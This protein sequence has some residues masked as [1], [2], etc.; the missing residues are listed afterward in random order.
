LPRPSANTI[1]V[2]DVASAA[3]VSMATVSRVLNDKP[4]VDQDLRKRV[5]SAVTRL[6]YTPHAAARALASQRSRTIGAVIP[7]L[8]NINFA[9]GVAALQRRITE[10]GY[11]LLL[12]SSNYDRAEELRQVRAL[13][14][15][16]VAGMMLVG[17][18]H[19]PALYELLRTKRIP[20]VNTW[21]LDARH[22]CVGFDNREIGRTLAR[23]LLDLGHVRFGV[24]SQVA[25][26]SD[27]AAER[28]IG[29][30]EVLA[31]RGVAMPEERL[32]ERPYKIVEGGEALCD[33]MR[34]ATP[35]TAVICGTDMLAF[36][37]LI[38]A[39]QVGIVVPRDLSVAGI[40]DVE[41][42]GNLTPPLTTIRLPADE[43]GDRAAEYLL[44]C[45]DRRPM[46]AT[47]R[48][49]FELVVRAS[50]AVVTAGHKAE[51]GAVTA[52]SAG[53]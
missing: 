25:A 50:T 10:A 37:A 40:N 23:H 48:V 30:R 13:A 38:A 14:A 18:R 17:G 1:T 28:V 34:S 33:L 12:G 31:A 5:T 7:T 49:P 47:S 51:V 2:R 4:S 11:T 9:V 19:A 45:I 53:A 52:H 24:I 43:I 6:G 20:F 41:Y 8:E 27:R 3:G 26:K 46:I 36:G 44:G 21:V 35:P 15:H 29:I 39:R 42:A 32:V 16:G 22:P